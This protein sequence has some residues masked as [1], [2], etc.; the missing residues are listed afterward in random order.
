MISLSNLPKYLKSGIILSLFI[1]GIFIS[2]NLSDNGG[3]VSA[4]EN[5]N[6]NLLGSN[7][8]GSVEKIGP[9]G[10]TSSKIRIAY[11]IGV[12][13]LEYKSHSAL[14]ESIINKQN[15]L[16][17][18]YYIYKVRVTKDTKNYAKS[19]MNGQKLAHSYVVPNVKKQKYNL[20]I[21]VHSHRGNYPKKRFVFAPNNNK[22]SKNIAL[23]IKSKLSWLSYS[24]PPSQTSPKYVT[25]PIVKSGTK[26]IIYE[27]YMYQPYTKT[28]IQAL[29]FVNVVDKLKF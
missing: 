25:I 24:F 15:S 9:F 12:H 18:C 16:N 20:V 17:Y 27:N 19:R 22:A 23:K 21:D 2:F 4:V 10:N 13:P 6:S 5:I 14:F 1:F 26:T 3:G 8:L 29:A 7:N 11:I 28:K